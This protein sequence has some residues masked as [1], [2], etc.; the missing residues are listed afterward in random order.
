MLSII[1]I[2]VGAVMM[3]FGL[4][5]IYKRQTLVIRQKVVTQLVQNHFAKIHLLR[6][7]LIQKELDEEEWDKEFLEEAEYLAE[8]LVYKEGKLYSILIGTT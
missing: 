6:K 4:R 3:N 2:F 7:V 8:D 5:S 1:M